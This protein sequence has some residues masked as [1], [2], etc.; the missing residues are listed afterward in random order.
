[1]LFAEFGSLIAVVVTKCTDALF[2]DFYYTSQIFEGDSVEL[3]DTS[4]RRAEIVACFATM[5]EADAYV[6]TALF[7]ERILR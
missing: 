3:E 6:Q 5:A 2:G 7:G 4:Q 1:M